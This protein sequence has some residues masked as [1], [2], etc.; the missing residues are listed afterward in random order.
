MAWVYIL[1]FA[2]GFI[3]AMF[4]IVTIVLALTNPRLCGQLWN[5]I[6]VSFLVATLIQGLIPVPFYTFKKLSNYTPD[7]L[8][9]TYRMTYFYCSHVVKFSLLLLSFERLIAIKYPFKHVKIVTKKRIILVISI[10][11]V[12]TFFVD[13]YPF[14]SS[15]NGDCHYNPSRVWGL[16]VI[17]GYNIIPFCLIVTNYLIIW[18]IAAK[19]EYEDK[20]REYNLAKQDSNEDESNDTRTNKNKR[21]CF[22]KFAVEI[23]ATKRTLILIL[24]YVVCWG[25]LGIAYMIDH[26]CNS[27]ISKKNSYKMF[28]AI[29]K[30][31]CFSSSLLTPLGYCWLNK[32]YRKHAA[33]VSKKILSFSEKRTLSKRNENHIKEEKKKQI[34]SVNAA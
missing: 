11:W 7:W 12:I 6:T 4:N 16:G 9:D 18:R 33:S 25:P 24:I 3:L 5:Y 19:F 34:E 21:F 13:I 10:M 17:I 23:K 2:V 22:I 32:T 29:L 14:L 26:F 27:C 15:A 20:R 30:Y 31:L 8:C 28:R 1:V